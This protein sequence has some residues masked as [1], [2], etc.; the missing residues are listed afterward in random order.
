MKIKIAFIFTALLMTTAC[1]HRYALLPT[2]ASPAHH[3]GA[4]PTPIAAFDNVP[5][6][7]AASS[8]GRIFLAFSRAID[9]KQPFSVAELRNGQPMPFPPGFR[10][11][12]GPPTDDRLLAVQALT[13]DGQN[14]LWILDSAKVGT[15]AIEPG[16]PKLIAIDLASGNAV[17]T[18]KFPASIAGKTAFLNDVRIDLSRNR[19]Y[20][21]DASG[22]GPNGIV[23]VDLTSGESWRRLNDHP[24]TKPDRNLVLMAEGYPLIQRNGP[25]KGQPMMLGADG[26]AL[27]GDNR[28]LYYS[29]LTSH[30]MYRVDAGALADRSRSDADVAQLVQD[31]GNKNFAAD[32]LLEDAQGRIYATDFERSAIHRLDASGQW[33]TIFSSSDVQWPDTL[34]LQADGTLLI[35]ATQIN[36]S[37]RIRGFDQ[38]KR[39]FRIYRIKTDSVPA[40]HR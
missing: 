6:G 30:E 34:A 22:E 17:Q 21:T 35:T 23:V 8:D 9:P 25:A 33:E 12:D 24:S 28:W 29:P 15:S 40:L 13:I 38:R 18:I 39:P 19:A 14:R 7:I 1:A 10:Q 36:W 31:L 16:S 26:I 32:G 5:V 27:S 11:D 2:P 4:N 3:S 37:P 20:L